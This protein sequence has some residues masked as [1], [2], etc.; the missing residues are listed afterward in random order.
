MYKT[1]LLTKICWA[2]WKRED[3]KETVTRRVFY[4]VINGFCFHAVEVT[5][6][7]FA[8]RNTPF[9]AFKFDLLEAGPEKVR[10]SLEDR[11]KSGDGG[12]S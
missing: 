11:S 4:G 1:T 6:S 9:L 2:T 8:K 5:L 12:A 3:A 10:N 7:A